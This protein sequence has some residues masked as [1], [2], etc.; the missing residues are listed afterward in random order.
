MSLKTRKPTGL[1]SWPIL[2][3]TGVEKSG[4]TYAAA[5]ASASKMIGRT[6]WIGIGEDDPDEYGAI[7]GARFEI[8][9]HDGT[10]RG[11][12]GS[13]K[14]AVAEVAADETPGLIVV[15]SA[16]RLWNLLS[17]EAQESANRRARA[18]AEKFHRPVSDEDAQ[19]TVDLWNVA[20]SRWDNVMDLLREHRGPSIVTARLDNT[21]IMNDKGEPTKDRTWKVQGHKSLPYDVGAIVEMPAPGEA[22][23]TGVRSLRVRNAQTARRPFPGFTVEKLWA[24]MGLDG[25][26]FPRTHS[27][28]SGAESVKADD[29]AAS[30]RLALLAEIGDLA[31]SLG[32][33][34][35][36]VAADWQSEHGHAIAQTT[37]LGSLELLRDDLATRKDAA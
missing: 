10:Y 15:D 21:A 28:A 4:K 31:D 14:A 29:D 23:L 25:E 1:P 3:L 7:P 6:L 9:E 24:E 18:K 17:D 35:A 37:D 30:T 34:R 11:V 33:T 22:V 27:A 20:K 36:Q 19:I 16:T 5:A 26:T 2:L 12:L 13:I 8:V 32:V